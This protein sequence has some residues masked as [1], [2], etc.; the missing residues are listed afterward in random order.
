MLNLFYNFV[1]SKDLHPKQL[2]LVR[3]NLSS[4]RFVPSDL[5]AAGLYFWRLYSIAADGETGP[6]G[7]VRSYEIK[8]VPEKVD[9]Q[10][11]VADD[12]KL[13]A[14]WRSGTPGQVYQAQLAYDDVFSD[15]VFERKLNKPQVSFSAVTGQIRYL[16]IRAIEADGYQ[17]AWGATQRIDPLPDKS[18]W[19]IPGIGLLGLILL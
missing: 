4:N 15:L 13:V 8:P 17:G 14:S 1:V 2:L 10:M 19:L 9:P 7:T 16:R 18:I 5:S 3:T 12:G 6:V 11:N